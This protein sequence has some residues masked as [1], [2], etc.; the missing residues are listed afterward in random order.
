MGLPDILELLAFLG[1]LSED[2]GTTYL[3]LSR[4]V[5]SLK[6]AHRLVKKAT[7]ALLDW[8]NGFHRLL[9]SAR[10][11]RSYNETQASV[12]K[13]ISH[14]TGVIPIGSQQR[15]SNFILSGIE[16]FLSRRDA[17]GRSSF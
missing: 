7:D 12:Y 17:W 9:A 13:S 6:Y 5:V 1:A 10:S 3:N 8:P 2:P 11:F 14:I 15:W 16:S 4:K